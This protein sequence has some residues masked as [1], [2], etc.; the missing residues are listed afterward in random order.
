MARW[1]RESAEL[2]RHARQFALALGSRERQSQ[3]L[4]VAGSAQWEP[5]HFTAHLHDHAERCGRDDLIPTLLRWKVLPGAPPHL[6]VSV[7]TLSRLSRQESVLI[8]T[9][10]TQTDGL[11][12]RVAD[13]KRRGSRILAIHRG[14]EELTDLAHEML[15]VG[16]NRSEYDFDLAQ[17][18][19]AMT[20]PSTVRARRRGSS[21]RLVHR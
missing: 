3:R 20:A 9:S 8:V 5:W 18:V 2:G 17:H 4:F 7:D 14:G 21:L 6:S 11:L 15:Y 19:A 1:L 13:A 16:P 12:Q 10:E